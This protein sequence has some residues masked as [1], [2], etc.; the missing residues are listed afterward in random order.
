MNLINIDG[1]DGT[2]KS[3]LIEGLINY[4]SKQNKKI[5]FLHFPRYDT[6]IGKVIKKVMY[7]EIDMHPSSLQMLYSS[8]RLNWYTYDY[9]RLEKEYDIVLVD[10]YLTSGMVYGAVDGLEPSE[11]LFNDRRTAKPNANIILVA[12]AETSLER[13]AKRNETTTLYENADNIKTATENYKN[14]K[15]IIPDVYYINAKQS[16]H[17]VLIETIKI[18]DKIGG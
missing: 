7:K 16:K 10:R 14:L 5:T 15:N 4:Y 12:D 3:T 9:P 8:D 11:I 18:I 17:N 1:A 6:E 13:M 2:G